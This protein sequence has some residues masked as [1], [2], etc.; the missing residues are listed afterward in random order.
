MDR[1]FFNEEEERSVVESTDEPGHRSTAQ[2]ESYKEQFLR[3]TADFA[4]FKRRTDKERFLSFSNGQVGV[5]KSIMPIMDN[6][7]RALQS[8]PTSSTDTPADISHEMQQWLEGLKL[9]QK[10]M[11]KSLDE[12]GVKQI[13]CSG[14][15]DP[16]FHDAVMQ[17]ES[18]YHQ[19][20]QIVTVFTPG[21]L[22][23]EIVIRPAQV[24]VAQ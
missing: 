3:V 1:Y 21:Y 9:V 7:D 22:F 13:D 15:F 24:S 10:A 19:K 16:H 18:P 14:Q 17:V 12:L 20:G 4:N 8:M 23:Q 11:Y 5:L 2:E 6:L